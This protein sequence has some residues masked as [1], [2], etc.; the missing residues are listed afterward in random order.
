[1]I[2]R[3]KNL[4]FKKGQ[5]MDIFAKGLVHGFFFQK[6][7]FFLSPFSQKSYEKRS[8]LILWKEKNDFK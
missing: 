7:N 5:K 4:S 3:P 8:F 2:I 6:S 1:M